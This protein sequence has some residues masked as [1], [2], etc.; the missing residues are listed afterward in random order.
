M[1][2]GALDQG[3]RYYSPERESLSLRVDDIPGIFQIYLFNFWTGAQPKLVASKN[4]AHY[5]SKLAY[6]S[7]PYKEK[8]E[9]QHQFNSHEFIFGG[10]QKQI[11]MHMGYQKPRIGKKLFPIRHDSEISKTNAIKGE[12]EA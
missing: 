11:Q 10:E 7:S 1:Y 3:L 8:L 12:H 6:D 4:V 9:K 2:R 5:G